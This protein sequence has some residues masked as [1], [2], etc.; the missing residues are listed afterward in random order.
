M[1]S[2]SILFSSRSPSQ[3]E[4]S[5]Y[6]SSDFLIVIKYLSIAEPLSSGFYQVN[7]TFD[8]ITE[9]SGGLGKL[10]LKATSRLIASE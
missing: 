9:V 7:L 2:L 8:P 10:G 5:K 1:H 6:V 4:L 3:Y